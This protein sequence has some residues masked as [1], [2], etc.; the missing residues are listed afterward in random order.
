MLN[1]DC[2][3][4]AEMACVK[5]LKCGHRCGGIK[6]EKLHPK[7]NYDDCVIARELKKNRGQLNAPNMK[8]WQEQVIKSHRKDCLYCNESISKGPAL[9]LGCGTDIFHFVHYLCLERRLELGPPTKRL[10]YNY[11]RCPACIRP[12]NLEGNHRC[13]ILYDKRLDER[14]EVVEIAKQQLM[15]DFVEY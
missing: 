9:A 1:D 13:A 14:K 2:N 10:T 12:L 11:L 15:L 4:K 5:I 8:I 6:G 3:L 7:C